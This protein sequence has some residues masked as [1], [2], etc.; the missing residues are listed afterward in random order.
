[1]SIFLKYE[2][3]YKNILIKT[4]EKREKEKEKKGEGNLR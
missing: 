2:G 4:S 3:V 1:L